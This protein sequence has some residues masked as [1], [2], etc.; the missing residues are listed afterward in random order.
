MLTWTR[1]QSSFSSLPFSLHLEPCMKVGEIGHTSHVHI[2]STDSRC[3]FCIK[4]SFHCQTWSTTGCVCVCQCTHCLDMPTLEYCRDS[5]YL[6]APPK[7]ALIRSAGPR[8]CNARA[9]HCQYRCRHMVGQFLW[10]SQV[11]D[12]LKGT[13][14]DW[15]GTGERLKNP[16]VSVGNTTQCCYQESHTLLKQ[17]FSKTNS[18]I[19]WVWQ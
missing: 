9:Q 19:H 11:V 14:P 17:L 7:E 5:S 15:C 13:L 16:T 10:M 8:P 18:C 3:S 2:P 1:V 12:R 6:Q 4:A